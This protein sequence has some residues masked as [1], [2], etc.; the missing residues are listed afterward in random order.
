MPGGYSHE[1]LTQI[2]STL[3]WLEE[4]LRSPQINCLEGWGIPAEPPDSTEN[5]RWMRVITTLEPHPFRWLCH[6]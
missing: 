2:E 3:T 1:G 6:V 5:R 4:N